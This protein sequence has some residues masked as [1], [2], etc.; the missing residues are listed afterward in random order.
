MNFSKKNHE[1][2]LTIKTMVSKTKLTLLALLISIAAIAQNGINYKALI[3]DTNGNVISNENI[4]IRFNIIRTSGILVYQETQS[5]ITNTDGLLI[6]TIGEGTPLG[7]ITF[8]LIDWGFDSHTLNVAVDLGSGFVNLGSSN[9]NYVPYAIRA[10]STG[11]AD[12]V[13]GLVYKSEGSGTG[14]RLRDRGLYSSQGYGP[15]GRNAIDLSSSDADGLALIYPY[16][17][18]GDYSFA[19][20]ESTIAYGDYSTSIGYST[21]ALSDYSIAFGNN[22]QASGISAFAAGRDAVA[23]GTNSTAM[24]VFSNASGENSIAIGSSTEASGYYS[25]AMGR[26]TNANSVSSTAI[27]SYN[28]GGGSNTTWN[29]YDPLF[30]IGNGT[31]NSN[32]SNALTVDK[33]G[34]MILN[35]STRGFIVNSEGL[36]GIRI[37]SGNDYGGTFRGEEAGIFAKA[38]INSNP[39]II[40][41]GDFGNTEDDGIIASDQLYPG[42]DIYLRSNDAVVI[43]LD[44]D[45]SSNNSSFLVRNSDDDNVFTV[46]ESGNAILFGSLTQNSDRRLKKKIDDLQY[47]LNEILQLQPKQYFWK[48]QEQNKKS[49][50][51][52]AQ[53]V[54]PIINEIVNTKDDET[55][56]LGISYIELIPVLINAIKEQS[57]IIE[58]QAEA[59]KASNTN[60]EALLS[61]I[62]II[63]SKSSN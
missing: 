47:G 17:A 15:I 52:I 45:D 58:N 38:D 28:I 31:S 7:G 4:Q 54:Q 2:S 20:G 13:E 21:A 43:Q 32:R 60:Y 14:W 34:E 51:L 63:E 50:G 16:G 55:K 46:N 33:S 10:I 1:H 44:Y 19:T 36:Y 53:D 35:S 24:G 39:D 3:K 12:N 18:T 29:A 62:E 61:R 37:S 11:T 5:I 42:S 48:N 22:S 23:S 26:G 56:T 41:G 8:D 49:L 27:G 57:K 40:L 6:A 59:L 25:T 9:L 30:E